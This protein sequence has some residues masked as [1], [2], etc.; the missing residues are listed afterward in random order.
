MQTRLN[1]HIEITI[2]QIAGIIIGWCIVYFIFP[3]L[4]DLSSAE[5]ATVSTIMFFISS[6]ARS[7]IL[8]RLFNANIKQR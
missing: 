8:R 5:L 2:N 7:Y 1:S 3:L 6:Y 4:K